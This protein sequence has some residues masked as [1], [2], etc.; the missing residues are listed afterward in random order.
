MPSDNPSPSK[1]AETLVRKIL[2]HFVVE[3]RKEAGP[4]AD[5]IHTLAK[6]SRGHIRKMRDATGSLRSAKRRVAELNR[7]IDRYHV[8]VVK[9]LKQANG[10]LTEKS[11][12]KTIADCR[13]S[14]EGLVDDF[15]RRFPSPVSSIPPSRLPIYPD[16]ERTV[17]AFDLVGYSDKIRARTDTNPSGA[18]S[19]QA[20]R[21]VRL[22]NTTIHQHIHNALLD[23]K[24]A[25]RTFVAVDGDGGMIQFLDAK[26]AFEFAENLHRYAQRFN[27]EINS[28][29]SSQNPESR[30]LREYHYRVGASHG[31]VTI[32]PDVHLANQPELWRVGLPYYEASRMLAGSLEDSIRVVERTYKYLFDAV[33][34]ES[35]LTNG[36]SKLANVPGKRDETF[37]VYDKPISE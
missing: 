8:E 13:V 24:V 20:L 36:Y 33:G 4:Y 6:M 23:T 25:D 11:A 30:R 7:Y 18:H 15:E 9:P 32:N 37:N 34:T 31:W 17:I 27:A 3:L 26:K 14:L 16:V 29:A 35:A 21:D 5:A 28:K 22:I 1:S 19:P 2:F 10:P 12:Q